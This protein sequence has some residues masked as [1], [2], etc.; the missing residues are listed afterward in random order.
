MLFQ[1]NRGL[2]NQ[3]LGIYSSNPK[4]LQER[5]LVMGLYNYFEGRAKSE[6]LQSDITRGQSWLTTA[7]LDYTP[8]QDIR[9]HVKKLILKQGRFM[10][11]NTP[12]ILMK[13][14]E[15]EKK[16]LAEQ[17]RMI[18][19]RILEDDNFWGK[20]SKAFLD[21]T[22]GKRVLLSVIANP[23]E[24]ISYRYYTSL[25]FTYKTD[26]N[27]YTKL[28]EVI[29]AYCE[30]STANLSADKQVWSRWKYYMDNGYC[31][32]IS[33]TYNGR[34]E[35]LGDEE[36]FNTELDEIPCRVI[37]NGGLTGDTEGT[38]DVEDLIDLQDSYNHIASDYRDALRFKMFEQPIFTNADSDSL[39]NIKIAP[40]SLIDLK[41]DPATEHTAGG[42]ADAKMLS[43]TFNFAPAADSF[44]ENVKGDMYE[45]MDQPRP[46]YLKDIPSAKSMK[47]MFYDLMSRC[48]GKWQEWEPAIKWLI[49]YTVK[50]IDK[51]NLYPELNA[52]TV[53]TTPTNIVIKHNYPIPEDEE[54]KK[55][56][57]IEEVEAKVR[58]HKSY[59]RD[60]SDIEDEDGEWQ[61]II[62]ENTEITQAMDS[63]S[64]GMSKD[65]AGDLDS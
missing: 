25:D 49:K 3:L 4:L 22:I 48:D 31:W 5:N 54:T 20:T 33:G 23:G 53:T 36:T 1:S 11:G 40:N 28:I 46:E 34:A 2:Q 15:R 44:L 58:S 45:I 47:F 42:G 51:F 32:L 19:E 56:I 52:K 57:A 24:P 13:P 38:S 12:S 27:D 55:K 39:A 17:K 64:L 65:D 43:S 10:L 26:P 41:T 30:E 6:D 63:L 50:C 37:I 14:F 18:I 21:C 29:I 35:S 61:E 59:I 9:N 16:D 60:L 7:D 62:E 8:S